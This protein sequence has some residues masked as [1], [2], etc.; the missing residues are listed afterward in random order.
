MKNPMRFR[1]LLIAS[2]LLLP[3]PLAVGLL[4]RPPISSQPLL[5]SQPLR[6]TPV[7]MELPPSVRVF[8]GGNE[9]QPQAWYADIDYN[10]RSLRARPYLSPSATGRETGSAMA[11]Q[12]GALVAI[13]GGYFDMMR[14]PARTFSLVMQDGKIAVPNLAVVK[15]PNPSRAYPVTRSAFGIR[16]NRTFDVAWIAQQGDV[17][18]AYPKPIAH[19]MTTVAPPSP[20]G[21][22][23]WDVVDAIGAGPTLISDGII[24]NTYENEVFFGSGFPDAQ[25]YSR[26]AIGYTKN[27]HLILL[28]TD[29]RQIGHGLTLLQTAREMGRLGCIEAM[30]LD[31]GGS[32]TLV[33][34]GQTLNQ[35]AGQERAITSILAIVP[36][37]AKTNGSNA[38][39][40]VK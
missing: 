30:N 5:S 31:G 22:K 40:P 11:R 21:G 36:A 33:V 28:V 12:L 15:R 39:S 18:L 37:T 34:K 17:L 8:A 14:Q 25:P 20:S 6:W 29:S 35:L 2:A 7:K 23:L 1:P 27:N 38:K 3:L 16:A 32:E 10:D 24:Q 9:A 19:T 26:A 4:A 13:N